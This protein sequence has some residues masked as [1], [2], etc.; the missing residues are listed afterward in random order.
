M[1]LIV[2]RAR[3]WWSCGVALVLLLVAA[4]SGARA[5]DVATG[6]RLTREITGVV[7][8]SATRLP[9]S[10]VAVT[11]DGTRIAAL[12]DSVGHYHIAGAMP[13]VVSLRFR[14][15]G[16]AFAVKRADVSR[17]TV[18]LDVV[19]AARA[20]TLSGVTVKADSVAEFLR[21]EQAT[22]VMTAELIKERR[23]QTLGETIRELPGVSIIQYGPSIAKP[24][25]RGLHSQ[26]IAT[27]NDGVPQE[28][29]Q[30]GGEHAPEIDAFAA[31]QIEV[32]RGPGT[33][34]Y[35][36]GA[37]GGV[38]RVTPRPLPTEGGLS[39]ELSL[40]GFANNRQGATSLMLEGA[41]VHL[42]V[43]GTTGWRAQVTARRA[44]D[45]RS[46]NYYLPN[47]GYEELDASGAL[48]VTREWG[49]SQVAYSLFSTDL[50]LYVGAH[51]GNLDDLT[52]A[53]ETPFTSP[54]FSYAIA[55]PDQKVRH[56][57][58]SWRTTLD[59]PKSSRLEV[60]Y[61]FQH[62]DRQEFDNHGFA[63]GARPAFELELYT[64]SLDI[65]YHHPP[66]GS[67][68]GTVGVSGMRQGNLSPG[69]SF[70]IPQ[71]R[72]YAGG[73]FALEGYTRSRLTLTA[74]ARFDD[75]YQHAYQYGAPVVVSP[76]D[77]RSY[78]GPSGSLGLSYKVT[79]AWSVAS[80]LS[81]SWRPPN[82]NERFS[83][84]VHHGT[85][86]YEIG[87]SSLVGERAYN[88]DLTLRHLGEHSR[89]ELST[90]RNQIDDFIYL[91]PRE[92]VATVRGIYPAYSY[93]QTDALLRGV[94]ISGQLDPFSWL[95]LTASGNLLRG[96]ERRTGNALYDMPADRATLSARITRWNSMRVSGGYVELGSTLVRRQSNVPPVTIYKLPTSG[97]ALLNAQIGAASLHVFG[98]TMEPSLSVR[99]LLDVAYRDYLSRYRL[100][101]DEPGRDVVLRI[102]VPFG[103]AK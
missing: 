10:N 56:D 55:R 100:F 21:A 85:A 1:N 54:M 53:M 48:G 2:V 37:L 46:P 13:A 87:D 5:Q 38:V 51:V 73:I 27:V 91:L 24:V 70:L 83:Q 68:T 40:N 78:A 94:E 57:L 88:A 62:N 29:Q 11:V 67:F 8:D 49:T 61:G 72:I 9:V 50:G 23:G 81:R 74:G 44:G 18:L 31:N 20:T 34:L 93:A 12:T 103:G 89:F 15:L 76:D 47:T 69:R 101:V 25:V 4:A 92:P 17:G 60:S 97:Y 14:R 77:A 86:Q 3:R 22:S 99:N 102:T 79:D 43:V 64:H 96:T 82:V 66:A 30:W 45:A 52:R 16:F 39:G 98:V 7:S 33:I 36:S 32:I 6:A 58:V 41:N 35:G 80:T 84:G 19:L 59:L 28:G 63:V 42:P 95:T 71:Y 75:R 65:Q 26:R 90:Y